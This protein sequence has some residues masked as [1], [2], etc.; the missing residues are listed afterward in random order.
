[1]YKLMYSV[2]AYLFKEPLSQTWD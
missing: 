2:R 1:M